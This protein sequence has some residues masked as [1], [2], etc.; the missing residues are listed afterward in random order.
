MRLFKTGIVFAVVIATV[1]GSVQ[2]Y[3]TSTAVAAGN[4]VSTGSL[5][6][7]ID[8]IIPDDLNYF[9]VAEDVNGIS[10]LN[11]PLATWEN[12]VP[13]GRTHYW[14]AF[15]N[16]G[17]LP[18]NFTGT[19]IGSWPGFTARNDS[20]PVEG[21]VNLIVRTFHQSDMGTTC[22]TD[23]DCANLRDSLVADNYT[24]KTGLTD[25]DIVVI[26]N[27]LNANE[28]VIYRLDLA[29]SESSEADC[30]QGAEYSFDL[31]GVATQIL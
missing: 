13:G 2:A 23:A 24:V 20:C 3:F 8:S 15:R 9:N 18:F 11:Q 14:V 1:A 5:T 26:S 16:K 22:A 19:Y 21:D 27:S 29:F 31:A 12:A 17:T 28:F 7:A 30:Y 10:T 25:Q 6:L 4:K